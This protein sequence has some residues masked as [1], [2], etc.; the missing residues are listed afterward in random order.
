MVKKLSRHGDSFSLEIERSVLERLGIDENTPL[1]IRTNGRGIYFE[2][3]GEASAS[4][5]LDA[6]MQQIEDR[7]ESVF[8]KLAE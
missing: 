6:V 7:Y 1:E 4:D 5:D 2:P 3:V 8:K